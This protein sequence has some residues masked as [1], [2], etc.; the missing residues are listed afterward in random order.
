MRWKCRWRSSSAMDALR[1]SVSCNRGECT[2]NHMKRWAIVSAL[3][4]LTAF[5]AVLLHWRLRDGGFERTAVPG[6][7]VRT[8]VLALGKL[9]DERPVQTSIHFQNRAKAAFHVDAA[10]P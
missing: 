6:L 9:L 1:W 2:R 3:L 8:H 5:S 7:Y 10:I 4:L